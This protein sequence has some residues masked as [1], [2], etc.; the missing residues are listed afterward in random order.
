MWS[1]RKISFRI[2]S[3]RLRKRSTQKFQ[4]KNDNFR[5]KNE[6]SKLFLENER[7]NAAGGVVA[8]GGVSGGGVV[9]VH[10]QGSPLL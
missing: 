4:K 10:Q 5:K 9:G 3:K 8:S 6:K 2:S 1:E 7:R